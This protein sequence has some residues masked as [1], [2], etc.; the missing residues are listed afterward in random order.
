MA[1]PIDTT[2]AS[3]HV[4]LLA[5]GSRRAGG[6]QP[7]EA[8]AAHIGATP[9]YWAVEPKLP[10]QIRLITTKDNR[11]MMVIPYF[12]F[13]GGIT[14]AI[15]QTIGHLNHEG[16]ADPIILGKPLG[17]NPKL[18]TLIMTQLLQWI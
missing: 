14:D 16:L 4:I 15:A 1:G 13:A 18:I 10:E 7:I 11:P 5:H 8:I 12:L 2:V 3:P 17:T 9:A 6:N